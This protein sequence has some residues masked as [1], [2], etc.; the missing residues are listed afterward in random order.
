MTETITNY[1]NYKKDLVTT[2]EDVEKCTKATNGDVLEEVVQHLSNLNTI[3]K[4]MNILDT[5]TPPP[6][7]AEVKLGNETCELLYNAPKGKLLH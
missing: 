1:L 3:D 2:N 5:N 4:T 7:P 6:S